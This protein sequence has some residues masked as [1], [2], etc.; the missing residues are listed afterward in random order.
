MA[1]Q[2]EELMQFREELG[3]K[4]TLIKQIRFTDSQI[5][6]LQMLAEGS[7][8]NTISSFI[9]HRLFNDISQDLKL[10]QI[11]ELLKQKGEKK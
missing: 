8:L 5:K 7:G 2:Q 10:N 4:K 1:K 3:A 9:R 6:R 11:L